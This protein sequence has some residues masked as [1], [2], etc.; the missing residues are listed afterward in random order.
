MPVDRDFKR[1]VRARMAKTGESY[2]TARRHLLARPRRRVA[3][4]EAP[5]AEYA[6]L[7]GTSD[8]AVKRSTG[9]DWA[10]WV[11]VLDA[12]GAVGWPHPR[13]AAHLRSEHGLS[14]WWSQ[15]VT[16][17]YERIRGLRDIG[18]RPGGEYRISKSK[19][20]PVPLSTLYRA[21]REAR[22]RAEW[23]AGLELAIRKATPEKAIRAVTAA[24]QP[25]RIQ[26]LAR[27]ETKST[28]TFEHG[29][30]ASKEEAQRVRSE[31]AERVAAL[32]RAVVRPGGRDDPRP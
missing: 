32:A 3:A 14:A 16:V 28:V 18:Q 19:T 9:S 2:T 27:G 5:P 25:V 23:A 13:I 8:E 21:V 20:V 6:A 17:A 15:T 30:L 31:W 22:R 26:F 12:L 4:G 10:S 7:A 1:R 11:A 24:G 29:G